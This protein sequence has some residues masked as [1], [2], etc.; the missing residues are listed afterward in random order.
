MANRQQN[1]G[2]WRI[3]RVHETVR[4]SPEPAP[5]RVMFMVR[6]WQI[7]DVA[8][9][10]TAVPLRATRHPGRAGRAQSSRA[11]NAV[12]LAR[13]VPECP[14]VPTTRTRNRR[15]VFRRRSWVPCRHAK[16]LRR[17]AA[18]FPYSEAGGVSES[19]TARRDFPSQRPYRL[20]SRVARAC[21]SRAPRR[22]LTG[23]TTRRLRL[24][25]KA[26]PA[27]PCRTV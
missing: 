12:R 5:K 1:K 10:R 3:P 17:L 22:R 26:E 8:T 21:A 4:C 18:A 19:R 27:V 23:I 11:R 2:C 14:A 6:P 15:A 7:R 25:Q 24:P 9:A 13:I 16:G 20:R